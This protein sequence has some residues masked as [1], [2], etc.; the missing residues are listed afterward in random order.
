MYIALTFLLDIS[1][2]LARFRILFIIILGIIID[3]KCNYR[4]LLN[5][6]S[7]IERCLKLKFEHYTCPSIANQANDID[8]IPIYF[9]REYLMFV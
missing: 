9:T 6:D 1:V 8:F 2:R 5:F 3:T 7:S 4:S